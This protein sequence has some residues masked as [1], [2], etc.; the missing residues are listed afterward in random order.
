MFSVYYLRTCANSTV[1]VACD[2]GN[3]KCKCPIRLLYLD[4]KTDRLSNSPGETHQ[5]HLVRQAQYCHHA[6]TLMFAASSIS[7]A[8]ITGLSYLLSLMF[9]VQDYK[10]LANS[11]TGLP[12]AEIFRQATQSRSG[13]FALVFLLWIA[14]GPC[15]IGSQLSKLTPS[16]SRIVLC[17]CLDRY[18]KGLLGLCS[19]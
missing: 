5:L 17:L 16:Y 2:R 1:A 8:F 10:S 15:M 4:I 18:R 7:I 14:L 3:T 13:T 19:G 11:P 6:K 12:L 9:S